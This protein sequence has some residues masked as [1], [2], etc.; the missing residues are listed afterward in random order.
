MR[1]SMTMTALALVLAASYPAAAELRNDRDASQTGVTTGAANWNS[2][3]SYWRNNF[4]SRPYGSEGQFSQYEPA[5]R[6]GV[7]LYN[8]TPNK[9][10]DELSQQELESGWSRARGTTGMEWDQAQDAARDAYDRLYSSRNNAAR[11]GSAARPATNGGAGMQ[12]MEPASGTRGP[13]ATRSPTSSSTPSGATGAGNTGG[14]SG[15]GSSR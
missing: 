6:Y 1:Q 7:E 12:G 11:S 4:S 13:A 2:E 14:A 8:R 9:R 15:A 3:S 10:F 5:Y